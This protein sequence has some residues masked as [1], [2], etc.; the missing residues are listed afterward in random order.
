MT[1][2]EIENILTIF[3]AELRTKPQNIK[4]ETKQKLNDAFK[5]IFGKS[6]NMG[7]S[8]CI[9]EGFFELKNKTN[10]KTEI[11]SNNKFKL[12]NGLMPYV[13]HLKKFVTNQTLTDAI[14]MDIVKFNSKNAKLFENPEEILEA[15]ASMGNETPSEAHVQSNGPS[16]KK[17]EEKTIEPPV[18]GVKTVVI[19]KPK[20]RAT[21]KK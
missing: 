13:G 15:V 5:T 4:S 12:K 20:K 18:H 19:D 17:A 2:I 14:A 1:E 10:L 9:V 8:S 3:E 11:M 6:I 16:E 7:C 21:K